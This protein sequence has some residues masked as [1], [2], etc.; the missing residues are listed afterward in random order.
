L[1]N[2]LDLAISTGQ[3]SKANDLSCVK[4]PT[5][6]HKNS[7]GMMLVWQSFDRLDTVVKSFS[8]MGLVYL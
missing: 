2:V 7:G 3:V 8:I 1:S 5:V 6:D 4:L